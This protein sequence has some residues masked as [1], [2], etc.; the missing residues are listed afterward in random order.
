[1]FVRLVLRRLL[2]LAF[3]LL[4][5]SFLTFLLMQF[6]QGDPAEIIL[7]ADGIRPTEEAMEAVRT[8][9]GLD[10]AW[11]IR[12]VQWLWG[13]VQLDLGVSYNSGRPVWGE[14]LS[15]LPAT[16]ALAA[17]GLCVAI[18]IALPLGIISALRPGGWWDRFS[19]MAALFSVAMPGFWLALMLV[20]YGAVR[21]QW[22]PVAGMNGIASFVLPACTL[23]VGMAGVYVRMIR[24]GLLDVLG[25]WHIK[26]ARAK[27]VPRWRVVMVH[28]L[29][30]ALLPSMTILGV[31]VGALMGGSLIV[32][33]IFAWPGIGKYVTESIFAKDYTVIQGYVLLMA[34]LVV[35]INVC[36]DLLHYILDP[37]ICEK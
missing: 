21:L 4:G 14:L 3:V 24:A 22:F 17:S 36:V 29:P 7:R 31:Q 35:L 1:M 30:L 6:T 12:Y 10:Q 32:E 5:I 23:G 8:Q 15:R 33:S 20:Y 27:G 11:Y 13:V 19:R 9:L 28:A 18:M 2:G 37:R 34:V 26:A 25:K 16:A